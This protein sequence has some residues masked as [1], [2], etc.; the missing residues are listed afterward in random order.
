MGPKRISV[1]QLKAELRKRGLPISGKKADLIARLNQ[2]DLNGDWLN[3]IQTG[4]S[5]TAPDSTGS[6]E[7]EEV[8]DEDGKQEEERMEGR[9][10]AEN[11]NR[12]RGRRDNNVSVGRLER[13]YHD[14]Q[15]EF[16]RRDNELLRRELEI[17]RRENEQ[18][19]RVTPPMVEVPLKRENISAML[20]LVGFF[21]GSAGTF[22]KWEQQIRQLCATYRLDDDRAKLLV[23]NKLKGKAKS[24]FQAE[25]TITM[26]L[27]EIMDGFRRM[28]D[29]RPT[30]VALRKKFEAREWKSSENF[31]DYFHDKVILA[32]NV[33]I[34][35][36]EMVD[37]LIDD[38]PSDHLQDLARMKE[39]SKK[40]DM[41]RVFEKIS[42]RSTAKSNFKR[43]SRSTN[44]QDTK[45]QAELSKDGEKKEEKQ[46]KSEEKKSKKPRCYNCNKFGHLAVDCQQPKREKGSCFRCGVMGHAVKD[47]PSKAAPSADVAVVDD[48]DTQVCSVMNDMEK[49][50]AFFEYI[51]YEISQPKIGQKIR[52]NTLMDTGSKISFVKESIVPRDAIQLLDKFSGNYYGINHSLLQVV[53]Y[54]KLNITFKDETIDDQTVL[55]V[56]DTTM[57]SPVILGRDTL[58]RFGLRLRKME[59]QAIDDLLNVEI[60]DSRDIALDSLNVSTE[61]PCDVQLN[62]RELFKSEYIEPKRPS[63]PRVDM[64]LKLYLSD[65]KPFHFN[66]RR[67]SAFEK[68][69][70]RK[71]L[72]ELLERHIIQPSKSEFASPIILVKKKNGDSRLC[73]DYRVLNKVL[74]RDNYPLPIIEDHIDSLRDKK[75]FSILDLKDGFFHIKVAD[76]SIKYTAFT[77]PFGIFEYR[78]MPFG[79]KVGPARFQRFVNEA[80]AEQIRSGDIV[81]YMDD[82]LVATVTV[83]HHFKVLKQLFKCLVEN[84]LELR[85]D[86]CRFLCTEV[87]FLGYRISESGVKPN[88]A[89]VNAIENYPT[90]DNIKSLQR[91]LGMIAYFRKFIEGFSVIAKPLYDQLRKNVEFMFGEQQFQ[92]FQSLKKRL[93]EAPI[94]SI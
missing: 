8:E 87:E 49:E 89:G 31:A 9:N 78:H 67:M 37:Y 75:Y 23:S 11:G 16:E 82:V 60:S 68:E 6:D 54:V 40:E 15:L 27:D 93:L 10:T 35:E 34:D 28:Y 47:C 62:L 25:N 51:D 83:D 41:L 71:I 61:I 50:G 70:L 79:L 3:G 66:P 57:T 42:L 44:K 86:K 92:A 43:D 39:F 24:W 80:L 55:V 90:P 74:R 84:L 69:K 13:Q 88:K 2:N 17:A 72:D 85:I 65:N 5:D 81:V 38:I 76:E 1:T 7:Y 45:L 63:I 77:T 22:R 14:M 91:F 18:L 53:G 30:R 21:D 33:P 59:S 19:R 4:T 29:H 94:L 58:K 20:E 56:P 26:T 73:V 48:V 36:E 52:L 46:E 12:P 64:E 32:K